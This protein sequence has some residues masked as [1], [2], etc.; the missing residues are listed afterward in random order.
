MK[1]TILDYSIQDNKGAITTENGERYY[2][3]GAEW[4]SEPSPQKGMAVD[5][6]A[7]DDKVAS[8]V[9]IDVKQPKK[10][11][12][13]SFIKKDIEHIEIDYNAESHYTIA[14]WAKKAIK[15]YS[16][17]DGRAR[18]KEYWSFILVFSIIYVMAMIIDNIIKVDIFQFVAVLAGIIPSI[19]ITIRRL[20]DINLSGWLTLI[21]IVPLVGTVFSIVIGSIDTNREENE[22]GM[23]A[24]II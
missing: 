21:A 12:A 8:M 1:G 17:F 15:S 3:S 13:N 5:F 9:Y 23:P 7:G 18:R 4:K 6:E 20:H 11:N 16:N 2:F 19:A 10:S 24:K 22:W 14:D